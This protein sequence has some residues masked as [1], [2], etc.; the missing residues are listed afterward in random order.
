MQ[1]SNYFEVILGSHEQ[2]GCSYFLFDG[3]AAASATAASAARNSLCR[4][5]AV[6]GY[7]LGGRRAGH[8]VLH[9]NF[10]L[11]GK[12]QHE[13]RSQRTR[14]L[15]HSFRALHL[16]L[17]LFHLHLVGDHGAVG[18]G[19][20]E[21]A[22]LPAH[23]GHQRVGVHRAAETARHVGDLGRHVTLLHHARRHPEAGGGERA[24]GWN[25]FALDY[26]VVH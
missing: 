4:S 13:H 10:L 16:F 5:S 15:A 26:A 24:L 9:L 7:S 11:E 18:L 23:L 19:L 25:I 17:E 2:F 6:G 8:L 20:R 3:D 1:I 12:Q 22:G 14:T 21:R